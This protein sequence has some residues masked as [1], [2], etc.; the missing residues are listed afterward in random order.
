MEIYFDNAATTR[1][2]TEV[3][4]AIFEVNRDLYA[5]PSAMH[6]AGF[7]AEEKVKESSEIIANIIGCDKSEIIWTSGGTE[8]NNM[9]IKG[10]TS[11][12]K[13]T[14][15]K[16]IT[17]KIEH[18][19]VYKVFEALK[20]EGF[21]V[22]YL[23]VDNEGHVNIEELKSALDDNTILVSIMYV[24]NE[25]GSVQKISD[26][27]KSIKSVNKKCAFHVDFV[28]GFSKY[29]IDVKKSNIDFLSISSHKFYG[30]K[31]VGVLY[32]S[33]DFRLKPL[34]V[35]GAQQNDMRAGTL[36][37]PGIVGTGVAASIAYKSI[38]TEFDRLKNLKEYLI[39]N[40]IKLNEIYGII[41]INSK[42]DDTFA[43]HIISVSFKGIRSEVLLHALE[44]KGIYVSA[45]SAC[46]S[47]DKK[48]SRTLSSIGLKSDLV[49]ST[50][51][52]SFGKYNVKEEIDEFIKALQELIPRL[53]IKR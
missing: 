20:D 41:T 48:I 10:Y 6:R 37:V 9:A 35:G 47:H 19:S 32:K 24:N 50:I 18:A 40:L 46:S 31:G 36:N 8:S 38:E 49:E 53:N 13:K 5:N 39:D 7:Y 4:N 3:E 2:D 22:I 28:Q 29:K 26:I 16:I 1:I 14:G 45:G 44:E 12:Y 15:N 27:G 23:N 21:D 30:P 11:L 34:I 51:R 52:I 33:K 25:I 43:P 42:N 17:T